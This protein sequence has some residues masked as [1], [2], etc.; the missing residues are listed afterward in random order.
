M[1]GEPAAQIETLL[2]AEF[3]R[4]GWEWGLDIGRTLL[5]G[6]EPLGQID[7]EAL[8]ARIPA[9]FLQRNRTTR[10]NVASAINRAARGLSVASGSRQ[11]SVQITIQSGDTYNVSFG[12]NA[13]LQNSPFNIGPGRQLQI[14]SSSTSEDLATAL[15]AL[16][17][18][19]LAGEWD[20]Q[21]ARAI[22]GSIE[23]Q[24]KISLEEAR[25]AVL[26]AGRD[27]APDPSAVRGFI[28]KVAVSG[29]GSFLSTAMSLGLTD[30]LHLLG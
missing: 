19:G 11:D 28:E 29:L 18:A 15:G 25:A 2:A 13:N 16:V 12:A 1:S 4:Q 5:D 24:Q 9:D 10:Q 23:D 26:E 30:L 21:A 17:A 20:E 3:D 22:G 14:D 7:G 6:V 27:V 8:A